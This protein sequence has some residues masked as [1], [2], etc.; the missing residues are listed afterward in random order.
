ML[1]WLAW[2]TFSLA[3]MRSKMA[4]ASTF[5]APLI[6]HQWW[7]SVSFG[8]LA[9]FRQWVQSPAAARTFNN[10]ISVLRGGEHSS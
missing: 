9:T 5:G 10:V 2:F 4:V 7:Q 1:Q 6:L 8:V 3:V